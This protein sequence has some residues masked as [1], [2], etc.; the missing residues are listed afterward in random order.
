MGVSILLQVGP[1]K[2]H[3]ITPGWRSDMAAML[4]DIGGAG[5]FLVFSEC[6][7]PAL[8]HRRRR[9]R[10]GEA[11]PPFDQSKEWA[12]T[13]TAIIKQIEKF[14]TAVVRLAY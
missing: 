10:I 6:D 13:F 12:E 7:L 9:Q 5:E 1:K 2:W 3:D 4:R 11:K 8:K 14:E